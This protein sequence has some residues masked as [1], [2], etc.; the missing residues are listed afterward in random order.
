MKRFKLSLL[1]T[2][3]SATAHADIY[4]PIPDGQV[5]ELPNNILRAYDAQRREWVSLDQFWQRYADRRGGYTWPSAREY[6]EYSRV[7]EQDTFLVKL[8]S[9]TCLMEFFHQRWRRA[10]DVRRWDDK[11]NQHS[12]C[13]DVFK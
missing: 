13:P 9:G 5:G 1:V 11:F 6:P 10:N 3:L 2:L 7:R 12:A 8:E 4:I